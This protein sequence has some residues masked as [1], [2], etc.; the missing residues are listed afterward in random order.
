[1]SLENVTIFQ[2]PKNE[3]KKS[4]FINIPINGSF[5]YFHPSSLEQIEKI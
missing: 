3:T 1:M 5:Q 2:N 4:L